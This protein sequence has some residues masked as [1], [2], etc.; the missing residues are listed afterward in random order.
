MSEETTGV[1][2]E[3]VEGSAVQEEFDWEAEAGKQS[4]IIER[5]QARRDELA[6]YAAKME[7][8]AQH[9]SEI[10]VDKELDHVIGLSIKDGKVVGEASYRPPATQ[11]KRNLAPAPPKGQKTEKSI[12]QMSQ[13]EVLQYVK[14]QMGNTGMPDGTV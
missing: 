4:E 10:E 12:E 9:T 2:D 7:V 3:Q 5:L 14:G 8:I 6:L 13:A 11:R 1:V